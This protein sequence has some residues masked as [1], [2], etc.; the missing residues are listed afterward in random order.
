MKNIVLRFSVVAALFLLSLSLL[1]D[2]TYSQSIQ[3]KSSNRDPLSSIVDGE[4]TT[5][6]GRRLGDNDLATKASLRAVEIEIDANNNLFFIDQEHDS[7]RKIDA[8]TG[9]ITTVAGNGDTQST[10]PIPNDIPANQLSFAVISDIALDKD[11]N[12]IIAEQGANSSFIYRV[13]AITNLVTTIAG[14]GPITD[15]ANNDGPALG[16]GFIPVSIAVNANGDI[17]IND[18]LRNTIR[19]IDANANTITTVVGNGKFDYCSQDGPAKEIA[20]AT[21]SDLAFDKDNNLIIAES[22]SDLVRKLDFAT[23]RIKTIAGDCIPGFEGD[24]ELASK[25]ILNS[26]SNLA[27]D[28]KGNLYIADRVNMR[29]RRVDVNTGIINTFVGDGFSDIVIDNDGNPFRVGRYNGENRLARNS[30]LNSPQGIAIDS[31]DNLYIAD[32]DNL[33][34]RRVDANTNLVTTIAGEARDHKLLQ[35]EPDGILAINAN[36]RVIAAF[37]VTANHD[38]LLSNPLEQKVR[39]VDN[40][41]GTIKVIAGKGFRNSNGT[42]KFSGDGKPALKANFNFPGA[43]ETDTQGNIYIADTI[44]NRIREIKGKRSIINTVVGNGSEGFC[45]DGG[46]AKD[47]CITIP[48]SIVFGANNDLFFT[49]TYNHTLRKVDAKTGIITTVVGTGS[50]GDSGDGDLAINAELRSPFYVDLDSKGNIY[51]LDASRRVRRI[52][53]QTGIINTVV[54]GGDVLEL[55]DGLPATKVALQILGMAVDRNGNIFVSD[56]EHQ[57]IRKVDAQTGIITTVAGNGKAGYAGDNGPALNAILSPRQLK[58]DNEGNLYI[59]T[60]PG[61]RVI[62]GIAK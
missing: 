19:R 40:L 39:R 34:I 44:N 18:L 48:S 9:I 46:A 13:D 30:S 37:S 41:T 22:G 10:E 61:I 38:I 57:R 29:I 27:V 33:S 25:A 58:I 1:P 52:D 17:F 35:G 42:G 4:I 3:N 2:Q 5:I 26:P 31:K 32:T 36:L 7:V 8:Q 16:A 51:I 23:G 60:A 24:G 62:K 53:I 15:S 45:G 56:G 49:D 47:A 11:G 50:P 6:V 21:I 54:G 12:L 28:S 20:L 43:V 59:I 55:G 14:G